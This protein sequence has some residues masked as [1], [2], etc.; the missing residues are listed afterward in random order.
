MPVLSQ[1]HV[2]CF[3]TTGSRTSVFGQINPKYYAHFDG[4]LSPTRAFQRCVV[5]SARRHQPRVVSAPSCLFSGTRS[6]SGGGGGGGDGSS[7]LAVLLWWCG[8][9]IVVVVCVSSWGCYWRW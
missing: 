1:Y 8:S 9:R 2:M 3:N 7:N 4:L 6:S 5:C